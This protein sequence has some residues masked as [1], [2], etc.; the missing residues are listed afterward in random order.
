MKIEKTYVANIYIGLQ[1]GYE[2]LRVHTFA[3]VIHICQ[4]Y[5]DSIGLGLT[6]TPT[7]FVYKGGRESGAIIGLINYPRFPSLPE[8]V[9]NRAVVLAR[10]LMKEFNQERCSVVCSDETIMLEKTE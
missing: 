8:E 7:T 6:V 10:R 3:E 4:A 5:C 2:N 9:K 1:E